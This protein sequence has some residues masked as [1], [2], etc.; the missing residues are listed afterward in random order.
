MAEVEVECFIWSVSGM[1]K[2]RDRFVNGM[3]VY[4][5]ASDAERLMNEAHT[6]GYRAGVQAAENVVRNTPI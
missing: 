3:D 6:R 4:V 2:S 1:V 5:R